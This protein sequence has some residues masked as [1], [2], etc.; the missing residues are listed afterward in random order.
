MVLQAG[1]GEVSSVHYVRGFLPTLC[2]GFQDVDVDF[3]AGSSW[4]LL[5]TGDVKLRLQAIRVFLT[6]RDIS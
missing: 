3:H 6:W 2:G 5:V 4:H 1:P